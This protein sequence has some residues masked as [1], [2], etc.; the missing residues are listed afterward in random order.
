MHILHLLH[1]WKKTCKPTFLNIVFKKTLIK[2]ERRHGRYENQLILMYFFPS[3][4]WRV[5]IL[6]Y[7]PEPLMLC[8]AQNC[9]LNSCLQKIM[10]SLLVSRYIFFSLQEYICITT[11]LIEW[12]V[13]KKG[14]KIYNP[15]PLKAICWKDNETITY[16][17]NSTVAKK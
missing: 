13:I 16:S 17:N 15:F 12:K 14:K 3:N 2:T 5:S 11:L 6:W 10:K 8:I 7:I 4:S 1:S 9:G